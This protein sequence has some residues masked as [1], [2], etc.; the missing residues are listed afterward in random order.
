MC[1]YVFGCVK[2]SSIQLLHNLIKADM[3]S[4]IYMSHNPEGHTD[5]FHFPYPK[6]NKSHTIRANNQPLNIDQFYTKKR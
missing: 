6:T 3:H 1:N 2:I 5:F 4:V